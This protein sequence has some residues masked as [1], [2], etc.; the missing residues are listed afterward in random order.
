MASAAVHAFHAEGMRESKKGVDLRIANG[1]K[2]S[3]PA[4]IGYR[5]NHRSF[6]GIPT[7]SEGSR[8]APFFV[9]TNQRDC[10][11]AS[12]TGGVIK[13]YKFAKEIL[14]Q[15]AQSADVIQALVQQ[16]PPPEDGLLQLS[17]AESKSLEL[18]ALLNSIADEVEAGNVTSIIV[19]E[20]KNVLRLYVALLPTFDGGSLADFQRY[21]EE[22]EQSADT[23]S[24]ENPQ[25]KAFATV[26]DFMGNLFKMTAEYAPFTER[27][28]ADKVLKIR[29]LLKRFFRLNK[30][31]IN[32]VMRG[33]VVAAPEEADEDGF[34]PAPG[35]DRGM[36][37][38]AA[39]QPDAVLEEALGVA[40][41]EGGP[42]LRP[43]PPAGVPPTS[44]R[45]RPVAFRSIQEAGQMEYD[46]KDSLRSLP[47]GK[48]VQV[49]KEVMTYPMDVREGVTAGNIR[50]RIVA[51]LN[52]DTKRT[53]SP[54]LFYNTA[55]SIKAKADAAAG[56]Q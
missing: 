8:N 31:G 55:K 50:Q 56:E 3:S 43:P 54:T 38:A 37:I 16:T 13:N 45:T 7:D 39:P 28:Q 22:V 34:P 11:F 26:R 35:P 21:F 10:P 12:M 42:P 52:R 41:N 9:N 46:M 23:K 53:E 18:N 30:N 32:S 2:S 17:D 49:Y 48:L 44:G 4:V 27:S 51:K 19:N 29:D 40:E 20:L 15:R 24:D 5:R 36:Q 25:N 47:L 33:V 6:N 1:T 14:G